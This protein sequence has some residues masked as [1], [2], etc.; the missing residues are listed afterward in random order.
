MLTEDT[1]ELAADVDEAAL[2]DLERIA[3]DETTRFV[4]TVSAKSGAVEGGEVRLAIDAPALHFFAADTG[5]AIYGAD[6]DSPAVPTPTE[7][8]ASAIHG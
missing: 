8:A 2:E 5:K 1:K 7:T 4:A 3:A 6:D